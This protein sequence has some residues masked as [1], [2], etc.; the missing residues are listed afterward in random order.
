MIK[1]IANA[2]EVFGIEYLIVTTNNKKK[3]NI[4]PKIVIQRFVLNTPKRPVKFPWSL[5][6]E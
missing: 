2:M 5:V 6:F 3:M 1:N 4:N